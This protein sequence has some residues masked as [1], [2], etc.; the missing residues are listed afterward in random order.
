MT[1]VRWIGKSAR[2][3]RKPT[4]IA[5]PSLDTLSITGLPSSTWP[6]WRGRVQGKEHASFG[7]AVNTTASY[8][9][10]STKWILQIFYANSHWY[11]WRLKEREREEKKKEWQ[12]EYERERETEEDREQHI[13]QGT[14][15]CCSNLIVFS[16]KGWSVREI[17]LFFN[18]GKCGIDRWTLCSSVTV[19]CKVMR[20]RQIHSP[21]H[22]RVCSCLRSVSCIRIHEFHWPQFNTFSQDEY[23]Q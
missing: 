8:R 19:Q 22:K 9:R 11:M 2:F 14:A 15:P 4:V 23:G 1:C 7:Q 3:H 12:R 13:F 6:D 21:Y 17:H 16:E 18:T 20:E 5:T 10:Q